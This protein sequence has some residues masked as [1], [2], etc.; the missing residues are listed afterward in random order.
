MLASL[1]LA[2]DWWRREGKAACRAAARR[3]EALRQI[4]EHAQEEGGRD[5]ARRVE[6]L[7]EALPPQTKPDPLRD[8]LRLTL[9]LPEERGGRPGRRRLFPAAGCE[10][11]YA[12]HRTVIFLLS[13]F[14]TVE[15]FGRL[16]AALRAMPAFRNGGILRRGDRPAP[17]ETVDRPALERALSPARPC[18]ARRKWCPCGRLWDASPPGPC[19]PVLRE[20]PPWSPVNGWT[21]PRSVSWRREATALCRSCGKEKNF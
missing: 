12:D 7:R 20:W 9:E 18:C 2:Q 14:H 17:V 15:D 16:E 1:D 11:E 5:A 13:P 21:T 19:A 10:P 4:M 6:A 8:P 3:V